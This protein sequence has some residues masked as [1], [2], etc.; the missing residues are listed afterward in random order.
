MVKQLVK[1]MVKKWSNKMVKQTVILTVKPTA[2]ASILSENFQWSRNPIFAFQQSFHS[3]PTQPLLHSHPTQP[4]FSFPRNTAIF[5]TPVQHSRPLALVPTIPTSMPLRLGQSAS[6]SP[7]RPLRVGLSES[8]SPS[9]LPCVGLRVIDKPP[10][11]PAS[12]PAPLPFHIPPSVPPSIDP[13]PPHHLTRQPLAHTR[14]HAQNGTRLSGRGGGSVP[15]CAGSVC[16]WGGWG[17]GGGWHLQHLRQGL[18]RVLLLPARSGG[19]GRG[20][21]GGYSHARAH[22]HRWR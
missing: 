15:V 1:Q 13:V 2:H 20:G 14:S 5:C 22:T 6:S 10:S 21:V 17:V 18:L 12:A 3:H 8:A 4:S 16:V 11:P 9:R 7:S 19:A